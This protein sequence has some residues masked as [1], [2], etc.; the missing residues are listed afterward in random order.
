[1]APWIGLVQGI[2]KVQLLRIH[3][4]SKAIMDHRRRGLVMNFWLG[5]LAL[6]DHNIELGTCTL[7][8]YQQG[9]RD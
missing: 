7:P 3:L 4:Q 9:F 5:L 8:E 2:V 1:M 6:S